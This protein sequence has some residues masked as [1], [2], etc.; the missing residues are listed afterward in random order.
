MKTRLFLLLL[1][2][3]AMVACSNDEPQ[4]NEDTNSNEQTENPNENNDRYAGCV[5]SHFCN[6]FNISPFD[7][8]SVNDG[9][10]YEVTVPAEGG[11]LKFTQS[12]N[13]Y[14]VRLE[15]G[16][17]EGNYNSTIV[18][19][20]SPIQ[21]LDCGGYANGKYN[22]LE[23]LKDFFDF[24]YNSS[25]ESPLE[26]SFTFKENNST[27]PR[28]VKMYFHLSWKGCLVPTVD[29]TMVYVK[30]EGRK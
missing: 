26:L 14:F 5:F 20:D 3:F 27:E 17:G 30:Q 24:S 8:V 6:P 23:D 12:D 11:E 1:P 25:N 10:D 15:E 29:A 16:E 13:A 28:N 7:A 2:L 19:V 9:Q 22:S 18:A 4:Q 21:L